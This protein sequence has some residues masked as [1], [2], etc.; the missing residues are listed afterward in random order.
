MGRAFCV[1]IACLVATGCEPLALSVAGAGASAA[2]GHTFNG[3][4]YRTFT[5]PLPAVKRATLAALK[6]MGITLEGMGTFEHGELIH[7][8]ALNRTVE[9]ELE[10]VTARATR[11]RVATRNGGLF[12]DSATAAEIVT[13]TEKQLEVSARADL[14]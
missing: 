1:F 9:I 12:Y 13:Q 7:A 6:R 3:I 14:D 5:A 10:T 11:M 4:T 8:A 2:L